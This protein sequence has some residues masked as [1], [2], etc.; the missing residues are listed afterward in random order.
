[1]LDTYLISQKGSYK[2][3]DLIERAEII[4]P[5]HIRFALPELTIIDIQQAG[6]CV[7]LD[8]PTGAGFHLMRAIESVMAMYYARILGK[9]MPTRMRNWGAYIRKLRESNRANSKI[10]GFLDHI[11]ENYRNPITHPEVILSADEAEVLL[12]VAV[13]AIRQMIIEIQ[14]L[15]GEEPSTAPIVLAESAP[16]VPRVSE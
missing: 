7:A 3:S 11:R 13:S 12:G 6:R 1:V 8:T 16:A 5:E 9:P 4:F 14:R 10:V 2:T 15:D